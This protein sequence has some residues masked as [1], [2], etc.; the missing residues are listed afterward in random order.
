[1]EPLGI[2]KLE[3]IPYA[4]EQGMSYYTATRRVPAV[5]TSLHLRFH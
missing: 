1:M 4:T 3:I 5:S 2:D